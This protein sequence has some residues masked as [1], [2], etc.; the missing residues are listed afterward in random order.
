[1]GADPAISLRAS[2]G[3]QWSP[4]ISGMT[5]PFG[6]F[7]T[8]HAATLWIIYQFHHRRVLEWPCIAVVKGKEPWSAPGSQLHVGVGTTSSFLCWIVRS[9]MTRWPRQHDQC[10]N[11]SKNKT[12]S[13][14][15]NVIQFSWKKW[16][17]FLFWKDLVVGDVLSA[18]W[19]CR[20]IESLFPR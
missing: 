12:N 8:R 9:G 6:W 1:M 2:R 5:C 15:S 3:N 19:I 7:K 11:L 18:M 13:F 16:P 10:S 4:V 20:Y 17:A 14:D